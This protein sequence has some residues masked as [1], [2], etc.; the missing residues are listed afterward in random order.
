M[1]ENLCL[2]VALFLFYAAHLNTQIKNISPNYSYS[3]YINNAFNFIYFKNLKHFDL[4]DNEKI[5]TYLFLIDLYTKLFY[6]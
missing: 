4:Y 3:Q 1:D 6:F 2:S 5:A